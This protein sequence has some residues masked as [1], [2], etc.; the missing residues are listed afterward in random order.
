MHTNQ[1]LPT[2]QAILW[3]MDGTLIDQTAAIIRA[4]SDV[5]TAMGGGTPDPDV[6][7]RSL[8]G[9]MPSTMGLFIDEANLAEACRRF[10]VRFPE[11]MLE[12]LIILAGGP[13]LIESSY[14]A[15]IAQIIFT[16][17]HGDT[18]RQVSKYAG[19]AKYIPKCIGNSD[20]D[21]HKPQP[22]LTRYVLDQIEASAE[23]SCMIGD[24]PTDVETAHNAGLPCYCV[25]TGAHSTEE[26]LEA[27]AEAAFNNLHD[28]KAAF[29]L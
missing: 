2:P 23:D 19:F 6:I 13:E 28:L 22:E 8:G 17:K 14:K 9:T 15:G 27:G 7:R 4:Y 10:R 5:I 1:T 25:A 29:A 3:D 11:I 24:S 21:W 12:G 18:A 16:N 20:T 26:L